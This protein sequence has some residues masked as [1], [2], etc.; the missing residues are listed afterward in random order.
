[1][2]CIKYHS[3]PEEAVIKSVNFGGDTDTIGAMTGALMG[4]LH[5]RDWI[6]VRWTDNMKNQEF[7]KD[8]I[9]KLASD[10]SKVI[11]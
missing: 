9:I 8:Y 6:P 5:G 2:A 10:L 7:G 11:I 4:A 3:T 1:L